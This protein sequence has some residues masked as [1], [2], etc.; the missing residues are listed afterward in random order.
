[1]RTNIRGLAFRCFQTN[2]QT[3]K[4]TDATW[5]SGASFS[6]SCFFFLARTRTT[7]LSPKKKRRYFL[8]LISRLL[9]RSEFLNCVAL[10]INKVHATLPSLAFK[11]CTRSNIRLGPVSLQGVHKALGSVRAVWSGQSFLPSTQVKGFWLRVPD[12]SQ[13]TFRSSR[14]SRM[15]GWTDRQTRRAVLLVGSWPR[16]HAL[17]VA[18]GKRLCTRPTALLLH[19]SGAARVCRAVLACCDNTMSLRK[20]RS[21]LTR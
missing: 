6:S 9:F 18:G 8:R 21:S 16:S 4:Q 12:V 15:E 19:L 11:V 5:R 1:V 2:K 20:L 17:S 3:N 13:V 7:T 10:L 14:A